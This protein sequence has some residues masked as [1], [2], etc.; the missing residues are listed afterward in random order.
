MSPDAQQDLA[1]DQPNAGRLDPAYRGE[2]HSSTNEIV[3]FKFGGTSLLGADRM[4]HAAG[5][6]F[7]AVTSERNVV[8]VVSA[9]KGITDRL[10]AIVRAL[11][12]GCRSDAGRDAEH[13]LRLHLEVLRNLHLDPSHHDRVARELDYLGKDLQ[14]DASPQT[15]PSAAV[16]PALQDRIAS[17]G[18]R[19]SAR[20]F[21]AALDRSEFSS[22]GQ[23]L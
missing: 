8:V 7:D 12:A 13:V 15:Q 9:M 16:R 1:S 22:S 2:T 20:L 19:F 4:L 6:V 14:H 10:L 3:A 5:L 21:A 18:E 17:Y 11:E 23:L